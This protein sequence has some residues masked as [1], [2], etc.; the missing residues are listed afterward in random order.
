MSERVANLKRRTGPPFDSWAEFY[1]WDRQMA[2]KQYSLYAAA[3]VCFFCGPA[4]IAP[5]A[6]IVSAIHQDVSEEELLEMRCSGP[7]HLVVDPDPECVHYLSERARN[8]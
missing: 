4:L 5:I 1:D 7:Y 6:L 3:L 8:K 2:R